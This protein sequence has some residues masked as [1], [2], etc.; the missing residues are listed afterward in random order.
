MEGRDVYRED[1]QAE[2]RVKDCEREGSGVRHSELDPSVRNVEGRR[3]VDAHRRE[4]EV[5]L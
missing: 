1:R 4:Q 2:D 5:S 3:K